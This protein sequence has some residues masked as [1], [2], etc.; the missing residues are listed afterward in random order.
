MT[1][2][3]R[4]PYEALNE[5]FDRIFVLTLARAVDRHPAIEQALAGLRYEVVWGCDKHD[6]DLAELERRGV[7]DARRARRAHRYG[8]AMT[9][10]QVACALSHAAIWRRVL[11]EGHER[12]L[13]FEDD[14]EPIAANL[15]HL[16][17]VLSQLPATFEVLYLGYQKREEATFRRRLDQAVYTVLGAL[18]LHHFSATEALHL[19]PR[20]YSGNLRRAGYHDHT[21]AYA[22]TRSAAR[23]LLEAQT[24]VTASVDTGVARMIVR[25]ELEAYIAVPKLFRQRDCVSYIVEDAERGAAAAPGFPLPARRAG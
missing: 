2:A 5:A 8:K 7:Y 6:L 18:G 25:G 23:K 1:A 20:P 22:F 9:P 14:A 11:D 15:S 19:L 13:V 10:G 4:R 17:A 24:P 16:P 12:V 3:L 21:H